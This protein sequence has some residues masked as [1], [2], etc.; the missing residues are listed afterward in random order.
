MPTQ[1]S[2][3][4]LPGLGVGSFSRSFRT[5]SF[6]YWEKGGATIANVLNPLLASVVKSLTAS[7]FNIEKVVIRRLLVISCT[8]TVISKHM[9]IIILFRL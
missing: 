2:V 4:L 3:A 1:C 5:G 6:I 9:K 7:I 8:G